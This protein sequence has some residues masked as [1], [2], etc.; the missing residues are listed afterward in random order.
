MRR[1]R[2]LD[3]YSSRALHKVILRHPDAISAAQHLGVSTSTLTLEC[4]R[5]GI[6]RCRRDILAAM[7]DDELL[8]NIERYG[9][10]DGL[11]HA[12]H[13][14]PGW[15]QKVVR[16]RELVEGSVRH[17]ISRMAPE[18]ILGALRSKGGNISHAAS[19][20]GIHRQTL[21]RWLR[22]NGFATSLGARRTAILRYDAGVRARVV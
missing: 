4:R 14:C 2:R 19:F 8:T 20:L 17:S 1:R 10:V 9:H 18:L 7:S 11:A 21:G 6:L 3:G 5:R 13:V 22:V 16:G 12:C 15:F